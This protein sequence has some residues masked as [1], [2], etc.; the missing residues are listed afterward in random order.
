MLRK[1]LRTGTA[2]QTSALMDGVFDSCC[3]AVIEHHPM[4][5]LLFWF[6]IELCQYFCCLLQIGTLLRKL[7][8]LLLWLLLLEN[9]TKKDA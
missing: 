7:N 9:M 1:A 5:A 6:R 3:L 8:T 2:C 4:M